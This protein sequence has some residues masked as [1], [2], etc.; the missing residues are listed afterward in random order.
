MGFIG[1]ATGAASLMGGKDKSSGN[2]SSSNQAYGMLSNQLGSTIGNTGTASSMMAQLLG[3]A[4]ASQA[5]TDAFNNYKNST[6]YQFQLG[7]GMDA[8]N[9]NAAAKGLLQSGATAKALDSYGQNLA[10]TTFGNYLN[11][12]QGV[13]NT[14][15]QAAQ[16]V[17]ATGQTTNSTQSSKSKKGLGL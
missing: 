3:A 5:T 4:P 7:Q 16:T 11:Q 12:L 9:G 2:S 6:G 1:G 15:L 13:A 8:I 10:S 17:G 14:G